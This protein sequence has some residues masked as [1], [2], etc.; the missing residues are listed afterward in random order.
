MAPADRELAIVAHVATEVGKLSVND[1]PA[2]VNNPSKIADTYKNVAATATDLQDLQPPTATPT[3]DGQGDTAAPNAATQQ[4]APT[5][6][7]NQ[8]PATTSTQTK[9]GGR[10]PKPPTDDK[11]SSNAGAIA[12][13][14]SGEGK[15]G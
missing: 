11:E 7:T 15:P 13:G 10:R 6:S 3:N 2:S 5:G 14:L 9:G 1:K 12:G 4:P 8:A